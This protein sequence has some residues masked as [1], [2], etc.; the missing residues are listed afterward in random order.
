MRSFIASPIPRDDQIN[1]LLKQVSRFPSLKVPN[2]VDLHLTYLFLGE[3]DETEADNISKSIVKQEIKKVESTFSVI[4]AFPNTSS[5]RVLILLLDNPGIVGIYRSISEILPQFA[6]DSKNFI[7]HVT[8]GRFRKKDLMPD[9]NRL[10]IPE[11]KVLIDRVCL[12]KSTLTQSG[13]LYEELACNQ[14]I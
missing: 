11:G 8:I 4:S 7:P 1:D 3:I 10:K 12:Y 5:P 6:M 9:I 13:P 2:T 14:L